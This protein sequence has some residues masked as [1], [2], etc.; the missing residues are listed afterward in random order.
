MKCPLGYGPLIHQLGPF[1]TTRS[2]R[3]PSRAVSE[4]S[5]TVLLPHRRACRLRLI[6]LLHPSPPVSRGGAGTHALLPGLCLGLCSRTSGS[7]SGPLTLPTYLQRWRL[8]FLGAVRIGLA[9]KCVSMEWVDANAA[10]LRVWGAGLG[11]AA[12]AAIHRVG[13]PT[14]KADVAKAHSTCVN[15]VFLP[16]IFSYQLPCAPCLLFLIRNSPVN[17]TSVEWNQC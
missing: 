15:V 1:H 2:P 8:K 13:L 11:A 7:P 14:P 16:F 9:S 6:H 10:G 3:P 12:A 5:H 17:F 4:V